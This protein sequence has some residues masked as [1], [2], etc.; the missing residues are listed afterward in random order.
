MMVVM[1]GMGNGGCDGDSDDRQYPTFT[2]Q[3]AGL[4][5]KHF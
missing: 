5:S 4:H 3:C 1:V 2:E